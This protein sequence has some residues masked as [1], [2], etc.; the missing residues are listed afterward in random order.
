MVSLIGKNICYHLIIFLPLQHAYL[1]SFV[2]MC[3]HMC[4]LVSF[5]VC[6]SMYLHVCVYSLSI[7][8]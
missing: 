5:E 3:M 1:A 7:L 6:F 2:T 8:V 4:V